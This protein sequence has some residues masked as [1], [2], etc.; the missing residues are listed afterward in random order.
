MQYSADKLMVIS[1]TWKH[2]QALR[3][4]VELHSKGLDDFLLTNVGF[5]HTAS[6]QCLRG[7]TWL[8]NESDYLT[9]FY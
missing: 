5:P 3:D 4:H 1:R 8:K 2:L 9:L 7:L 6:T